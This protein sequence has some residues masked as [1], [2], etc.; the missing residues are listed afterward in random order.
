MSEAASSSSA[1]APSPRRLNIV[2]NGCGHGELDS[3]YNSV[4]R[5][6]AA[7]GVKV[8]VLL[9]CGDFQAVRNQADLSTMACP[10]KY[11]AMNSFWRYYSGEKVAPV[12][13][14]FI[15]GNHEASNHNL[16]LY[17]GGWAA[18]NIYFLGFAGVVSVG[19]VRIGGLSGIYNRRHYH[20]GHF[21]APPFSDDD[22]RSVY[23]VRELE[24]VRLLALRRPID[25][26]ASHDWPQHVAR[27]GDM[28]GLIRRKSFL[29][30]E[31]SSG[32]LG[33]PP[34][35]QLLHKLQPSFWFAAHLHVKFAAVVQH[36]VHRYTVEHDT[37]LGAPQRPGGPRVTR[38]LSL[39]K[40]LPNRDFLQLITVD[41]D[42]SPPVLKYDA[43]WI[44]VLKSTAPLFSTRRGAVPLD[45]A[46]LAAACGGRTDFTPTDDECAAVE[47]CAGGDLTVPANFAITAP[48]HRAGDP[49]APQ[50]SLVESPQTA[51]FVATFGLPAGFRTQGGPPPRA[52]P[53][54]QQPPPQRP[55]PPPAG[56][57]PPPP[58]ALFGAPPVVLDSEEIELGDD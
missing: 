40:C 26:F 34:A 24:V 46:S 51:A 48:P 49:L 5:L 56:P 25:V 32:S 14:I 52:P 45:A 15:G 3:L 36:D 47:A 12:L 18:P 20:H 38:F 2:V 28:Q 19:G 29:Q 31:L 44:A 33:S 58:G 37:H 39:D 22:M 11:R 9:I 43:E 41:G 57:P 23:H 42:G 10:P 50:P 17:Y 27:H 6:E 4:A 16:E 54:P 8:D 35:A 1:P 55:P 53:P 7:H 30:G 13:T 21:E